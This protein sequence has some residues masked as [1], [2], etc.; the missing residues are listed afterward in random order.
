MVLLLKIYK[1][2]FDSKHLQASELYSEIQAGW[3]NRGN[4]V[5]QGKARHA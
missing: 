2:L 5:F 3:V 4:A 1:S